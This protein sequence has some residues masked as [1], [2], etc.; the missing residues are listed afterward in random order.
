MNQPWRQ[1]CPARWR[2]QSPPR[3]DAN[4]NNKVVVVFVCGSSWS[5]FARIWVIGFRIDL[6]WLALRSQCDAGGEYHEANDN[7]EKCASAFAHVNSLKS[8]RSQES[9]VLKL[10][11]R[12]GK[13]N[14]AYHAN[15]LNTWIFSGVLKEKSHSDR[16]SGISLRT[17]HNSDGSSVIGHFLDEQLFRRARGTSRPRAVSAGRSVTRAVRSRVTFIRERR[18]SVASISMTDPGL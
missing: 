11:G 1:S 12:V 5:N 13:R 16:L 10:A 17:F 4:G 15:S 2:C 6:T 14:G 7:R 3:F 9:S 8:T 18:R